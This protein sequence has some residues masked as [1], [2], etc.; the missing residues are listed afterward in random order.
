LREGALIWL[1]TANEREQSTDVVLM[2]ENAAA[3]EMAARAV[4]RGLE[5]DRHPQRCP[6]YAAPDVAEVSQLPG[7]DNS[8]AIPSGWSYDY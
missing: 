3:S 2:A 6:H 7:S 1:W 8:R 4:P 5:G